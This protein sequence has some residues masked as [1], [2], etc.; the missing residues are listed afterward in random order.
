M[1]FLKGQKNIKPQKIQ[2]MKLS[3]NIFKLE[4]Y[5]ENKNIFLE[6]ILNFDLI[7]LFYKVNNQYFEAV[8]FRL[9][10]ENEAILFILMKPLFQQLG[11]HSRYVNLKI[12]KK[13]EN[14]KC[15]SFTANVHHELSAKA[16]DFPTALPSPLMKVYI[17]FNIINSHNIHISE[18]LTFDDK[19]AGFTIL[20][21]LMSPVLKIIF[22][23]S[24]QAV[25]QIKLA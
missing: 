17:I 10:N 21:K 11:C 23:Q 2:M 14:D 3:N 20:E 16:K 8:D 15:I 12:T 5:V 7:H 25:E 9:L 6:K 19:Y 13:I 22:K 1:D 18:E 4:T 24:V